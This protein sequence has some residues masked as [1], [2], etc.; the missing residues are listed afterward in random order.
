MRTHWRTSEVLLRLPK[1]S[2][3]FQNRHRPELSLHLLLLEPAAVC[4]AFKLWDDND[5]AKA[6]LRGQAPTRRQMIC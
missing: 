2:R 1:R 6:C 5:G 4:L 3:A